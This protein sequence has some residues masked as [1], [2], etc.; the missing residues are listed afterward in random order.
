MQGDC[1]IKKKDKW[2]TIHFFI[3]SFYEIQLLDKK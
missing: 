3:Y 1:G 2:G